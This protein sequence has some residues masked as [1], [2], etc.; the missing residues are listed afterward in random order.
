MSHFN[1]TNRRQFLRTSAAAGA[2]AAFAAPALLHAAS[3]NE[4]LNIAAVGVAGRAAANV[5]GVA[6]ENIVAICDVDEQRLDGAAG[7]FPKAKKFV[8]F[9]KMLT[10]TE[11]QID[12]VVVG[13]PDHIHMPAGVMAMRMGKHCYAEKPLAH[14]VYDARV[15]AELAKEKKLATQMGTQ[16]HAGNN[17]RRVVEMIGAGAI[18]PVHEVHVWCGKNWGGGRRPADTP[19]VPKTLHWDLWLGPAPERPYH[20][21]YLPG[22]WRR[23]WDFGNGTLGDMAC[24]YMDLPFWALDLR[25][26]TSIES[27]GPPVDPEGCPEKLIV[28]YEF[29]AR[30]DMPPVK[31]TWYDGTNRP[32]LPEEWGIPVGGSGVL[33]VGKEGQMRA[34]YGSWSL[35]PKKKFADYEPPEPTI[36]NSIGHHKE[37]I[38]ACKTG[39]ETT[40][41]FNYSGALS[42]AV[43]LGNVAFRVGKK[44]DW[45]GA[46]MKATNCP[47]A[48]Q[49]LRREYRKGWT[50]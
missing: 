23:W 50:L 24:H 20:S 37:W 32:S 36:P 21:C 18:G 8:D 49:Y 16:I 4:K 3:P 44:L 27:E 14:N 41:N 1:R 31:F 47:E 38:E 9:R 33:F 48:D 29:P 7:K 26:P 19:P 2:A 46:K 45:D 11:K 17:Y 15:A 22:N 6:S 42:E 28:R 30:G 34:D 13:T 39:S 10:E 40:C 35:Y 43:L 25:H 12:A 5:A